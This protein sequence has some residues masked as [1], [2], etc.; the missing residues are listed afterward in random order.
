M[1]EYKGAPLDAERGPGLGCFWI[2]IVLL[3]ALLILTPVSV[4]WA[5]PSMVSAALLILSL[6]LLFFVGQ[7]MIFL[8]RLVAAD[9]RTRRRP[10]A[11]TARKTVGDLEE[12]SQ[13]DGT[14]TLVLD[15]PAGIQSKDALL[16]LYAENLRFPDSFGN[17]WD[18]LEEC[19]RD[20]SWLRE[21]SIRIVHADQPL[22][23]DP[24]SARTYS[25]ILRGAL[26]FWQGNPARSLTIDFASD[27]DD[28]R[29]G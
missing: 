23:S 19:L 12:T 4:L 25:E 11:P 22:S 28:A 27:Q 29:T 1:P 13:K 24:A 20:L 3:V 17:N 5:W 6:V 8:L 15:V 18:A 7:T 16:G 14:K 26:T 21:H 2:Q 10:L 9:R